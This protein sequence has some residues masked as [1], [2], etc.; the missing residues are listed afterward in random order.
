MSEDW[1]ADE[2]ILFQTHFRTSYYVFLSLNEVL[3]SK[4]RLLLELFHPGIS[5]F[6]V[7]LL[8]LYYMFGIC[9][10]VCYCKNKYVPSLLN[11]SFRTKKQKS[12]V[13]TWEKFSALKYF[14]PNGIIKKLDQ[15]DLE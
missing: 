11:H 1:D 2:G 14:L 8:I 5:P 4:W 13:Y 9:K 10:S 7:S 12:S 6:L 15:L 3:Y